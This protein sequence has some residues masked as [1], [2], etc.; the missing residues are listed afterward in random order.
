MAENPYPYPSAPRE[1][2]MNIARGNRK[3][4]AYSTGQV[5]IRRAYNSEGRLGFIIIAY[6]ADWHK[7]HAINPS[8]GRPDFDKRTGKRTGNRGT[9]YSSRG[10]AW[11]ALR[12]LPNCKRLPSVCMPLAKSDY[13][14]SRTDRTDLPADKR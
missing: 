4:K 13:W 11:Q 10:Q 9:W 2:K 7:A 3:I 5:T 14:Y 12:N 1:D 6:F 8:D